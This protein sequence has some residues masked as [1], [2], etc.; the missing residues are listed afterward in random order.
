[1]NIVIG[2]LR[3]AA[4]TKQGTSAAQRAPK[5]HR[6][7][8]FAIVIAPLLVLSVI[9]PS[10]A[11]ETRAAVERVESG[12]DEALAKLGLK[13]RTT[14]SIAEKAFRVRTAIKHSDFS[15]ARQIAGQILASSH[16]QNWRYYPFQDFVASVSDVNDASFE[17]KLNA[18]V[19]VK[20]SDL[21]PLI[22]RAQFHYDM[23]WFKRGRGFASNT[24]VS[25][26]DDFGKYMVKALGDT[27]AV[28]K[29]DQTNPYAFYLKLQI[30]RGFGLTEGL[31]RAFEEAITKFPTYYPLYDVILG[32]LQPKWGGTPDAMRSFVDRY[33]AAAPEDSPLKLLYVSLYRNLLTAA[34]T[35]CSGFQRNAHADCVKLYMG[36]NASAELEQQLEAALR[37]YDKLDK[38][39]FN[40]AL[41]S[42]LLDMLKIPGGEMYS[43]AV[44]ELAANATHSDTRLKDVNTNS[45]D[46]VI[47]QLVGDSWYQKGFYDDAQTKYKQALKGIDA[48]S[49]PTDEEKNFALA[50]TYDRLAHSSEKLNHY[51]DMIAHETAATAFGGIT[52]N[53]HFICYGYYK[54]QDYGRAVR[55]CTEAIDKAANLTAHYWRGLVYHQTQE[56]EAA[57]RDLQIVID[58]QHGFRTSAAIRMSVIY[59]DL[60]DFKSSVE[61]LN[62][63][64]FLYNERT[65]KKS[66]IA[67]VYNNRCY[68][69]MELGDLQKA[70]DDCTAS[71]RYGSL[72][73]AYRKQQELVKRLKP[74]AKAS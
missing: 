49:F 64:D 20:K 12:A 70:L 53:E 35:S 42:I 3:L 24:S 41:K 58:S 67:T 61:L 65:Q 44:L 38:H 4:A 34:S 27:D 17:E 7:P 16:L 11:A 46:Y 60:K 30:V 25:Q 56:L 23:G 6:R 36:T 74:P 57:L 21:I 48:A 66:D 55:T 59:D 62:R 68:A 32:T 73:E 54:L 13:P 9:A 33:A 28:I 31:D 22:V 18:W 10:P 50:F 19:E 1:M 14:E 45:N 51:V 47:D 5:L 72:P 63:Y 71:L 26:M 39:Q 69:Y 43:G 8:W 40:I 52:K 29:L 2:T 37:L 15:T